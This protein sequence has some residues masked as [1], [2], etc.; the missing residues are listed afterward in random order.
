MLSAEAVHNIQIA[1]LY[2][3]VRDYEDPMQREDVRRFLRSSKC[4]YL[5]NPFFGSLSFAE[6]LNKLGG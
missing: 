3:A 2:Q 6:I 5:Y 4:E 1:V